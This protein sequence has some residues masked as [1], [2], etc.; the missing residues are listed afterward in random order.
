M[1]SLLKHESFCDVEFCEVATSKFLR[2]QFTSFAKEAFSS[3][4]PSHPFPSLLY[5]CAQTMLDTHHPK[6]SE[7]HGRNARLEDTHQHLNRS[8]DQWWSMT[9]WVPDFFENPSTPTWRHCIGEGHWQIRTRFWFT[10][11]PNAPSCGEWVVGHRSLETAGCKSSTRHRRGRCRTPYGLSK[12]VSASC[13]RKGR[14]VLW[15]WSNCD[16]LAQAP[17][18]SLNYARNR[19][20]LIYL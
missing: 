12:P 20:K 10:D 11:S 6:E 16:N 19:V 8:M 13:I 5:H 4:G 17:I 3:T 2:V 7:S 1:A 15:S 18:I 14:R 9:C